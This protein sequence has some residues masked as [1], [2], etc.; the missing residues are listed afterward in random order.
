M[1]TVTFRR[2]AR[3]TGPELPTGEISLHEPPPMPE[4]QPPNWRMAVMYL[5]MALMSGV[6]MLMFFG[7]SRGPLTWVMAAMMAVAMG[8]MMA[9]NSMMSGADRRR[10]L[11]GDRRDYLRYLGQMRRRVRRY[12]DQQREAT[13]WRHPH[14]QTLWSAA[15][16]TRRWER[17]PSHP[18]FLEVRAGTGEQRLA[19]RIAPMQTKPVED[20]EPLS[21][22]ALRRFIRAYTAVADQPVAL[23]LPGFAEV[24]L[25][26]ETD[27]LRSLVRALLAQ[28]VTLHAPGEVQVALC[29]DADGA[30]AWD[31]VK[32]LPHNQHPTVQDAAGG[33]RLAGE[34]TEALEHLLGEAFR[35]R[36]RYETGSA[37]TVDEPYV[38]VLRDGGRITDGS[39][40]RG[41]GYRNTLLLDLGNA[42]VDAAREVLCLEVDAADI[43]VLQH[44]RVGET[45]RSRLCA[46]DGLGPGQARALA[47]VLSPYRL[48]LSNEPVV[49]PLTA[50]FDLAT[51]LGI[52]DLE[53]LDLQAMWATR[54]DRDRLRVPIGIDADGAPVHV[55]L[56]ESALGGM[57]PHGMLIG[58]TGSGKSEL[59]R[60]LVLALAATHSSETLNLV[61]V[62]FKGGAT[63][64]G[65][66]RLPHTSAVITNLADEAAL[67][68]RMH[69]ALRGE[70]MRRQEL[71]RRA[72]G[73]TSVL[74]YERARANGTPMDPLPTLFVVVDEF[75]ELLAAH[76]DFIDLFAMIG[77]LGRS[78]AVHLLLASQRV[79]DGR[80]GQL[81]SHLS[82][83]IGLRTFSAMESRSVIGVPDA[84]E[85]PGA[86]GN[87]YLRTDIATLVRFKAAYVSGAYRAA[88]GP[89]M[90]Q[91]T[92]ER[93][94]VPY[95]LEHIEPVVPVPA[96]EPEPEEVE[97]EAP[98]VSRSVLAVVV[99]QLADSGPPAHQVWLPPLAASPTLDALLP[100]LDPVPDRGLSASAW[101]GNGR[102][103]VP[104]GYI[105][106]PFE[107]LRD[108]LTVDLAGV[109][110]HLGI[111]GGPRSGKSTLL[112]TL[113]CAL[114]LTHTPREVQF[115]CL[116]FGGGSLASI[117][118]LPH[119]GSVAGRLDADRVTRTV[120]EVTALITERERR[121]AAD[122]IDGMDTY[123][124]MRADGRITDDPY[125]DVFLV[126]DGWFTLR[127]DFET[128]E[129]VV[130][131]VVTRGL[132]FGVH[133]L[134]TTA[135]WSE[136]HHTMRDQIGTK[137]E[138]H[139]G[140]AVDSAID[141]R[142]AAQVPRSPGHGLT[143]EKWFFLGG[144]P[145]VDGDPDA[146][147][148]VDAGRALADLVADFWTGPTAPRVR[149]LPAVRPAAE[150][151]PPEGDLKVAL[152]LD[153]A[154]MEPLWHDFGM[155]P[156]LTVLG[157]T[158]S[159]KTN[160]LRHIA[161]AI[162][163]RFT[164]AEARILLVDYRRQ[165][166]EDVPEEYRLGY[167]VSV[168]ATKDAVRDAVAGL[169]GRVPD[170]NVT[171]EQLRR[172]DWWTGPRLF[173]LVDDFDL[174]AG[175]DGPLQPLVPYLP[176]GADIGF[177][178]VLARGAAG[179]MRI[180]MDAVLRRMQETNTPD[181]A[182]S[183]P[184]GEGPLLGGYKPRHLP[185]GRAALLTRRGAR[186][187]QT[188]YCPSS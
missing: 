113:V 133:L 130:R 140:D 108:V 3:R 90:R 17:R 112:R 1:P 16:T 68:G 142:L 100:A 115:Y 168:D 5:P 137:L 20:L 80:I 120:A 186:S 23:F 46:P 87:G 29:V 159:G 31:F 124:R 24:R 160:L 69:E 143:P 30:Q 27:V 36:G 153:E 88:G 98:E 121:F 37:V 63:F 147:S 61:L 6:M 25:A 70:L 123:R 161:R 114:A 170:A 57:G 42:A 89:R 182:L 166:F 174:L 125:G 95:T 184:P 2:P 56:K 13:A 117:A 28:V 103:V 167:A 50:N 119:V 178:L 135:R 146:E 105:D 55:D 60:T 32:W 154:R 26:G 19:V 179:V 183:C 156:H 44:D 126:V 99:D 177:H 40:L 141:L 73:Y 64:L 77:R 150:L 129:P 187:L 62:D 52:D 79:D 101:P 65:L 127:Q 67:V 12:I 71:L 59:L 165:L 175:A 96:P 33:R 173:V 188:A 35:T 180:S 176:N 116:D 181:L 107:Q 18:D 149:T 172:R 158:E 9:A 21:A 144:L 86:P 41:G 66:D 169:R 136:V 4:P 51:L 72:G 106:K 83:R 151:P 157:D 185:P 7:P 76:R 134:L 152:G 47:R 82:Y 97:V 11:G 163:A 92:I 38:I 43:T 110:G 171:A 10:K 45:T 91:E 162:V 155:L 75:S 164:P 104:L 102:L 93:R 131:E 34:T 109:G 111:A 118:G 85:L 15:M 8:G 49:E 48:G 78:L 145:R 94:V 128:V 139:L 39:R 14:P 53:H 148:A 74:E 81:E 138:L 84:Y 22:K 58:A 132:N 122:R 54:D